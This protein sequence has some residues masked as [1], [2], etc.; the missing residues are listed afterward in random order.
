M[1][2][3]GMVTDCL[4]HWLTLASS[5]ASHPHM[6]VARSTAMPSKRSYMV[7]T[8]VLAVSSVESPPVE[9]FPSSVADESSTS[10]AVAPGS[11]E[12]KGR[13]A[14]QAL[15]HHDEQQMTSAPVNDRESSKRMAE[16]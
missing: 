6:N 14:P 13:A 12:D 2:G 10:S 16:A 15:A 11:P 3:A 5:V 1:G 4:T 7:D 8:R 9:S